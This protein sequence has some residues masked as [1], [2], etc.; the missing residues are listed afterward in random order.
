MTVSEQLVEQ[1]IR[2]RSWSLGN[3][4]STCPKCSHDR[5]NKTEPCLSVTIESDGA[6]WK[7]HHCTWAG[8]VHERRNDY[9][10]APRAV[11]KV[12]HRPGLR[13]PQAEQYLTEKRGLTVE[14]L[15]RNHVGYA[16]V[17]MPG[18]ENG[19]TVGAITF[20]YIRDG[21]IQNVKYRT[22][23]KRFRQE[24]GAAKI[25]YGLDAAADA[26]TLVMCEGEIDKLSFEV[27]GIIAVS[28]PDGAPAKLK[29]EVPDPED[30]RKFEYL[31][32]FDTLFPKVQ[33]II[34]ATDNDSPGDV[35]AE[36]LSRRLGKHRCWRVSWPSLGDVTCKDANEVLLEHGPQALREMVEHAR[37]YPIK[38]LS[39]ASDFVQEIRILY[40]N[41]AR[42]VVST[43]WP[44]MDQFWRVS[45]SQLALFTGHTNHG[46]SQ[47]QD[48]LM[49]N[50]AQFHGWKF[51]LC[52]MEN[53]RDEH[54]SKL[55]EIHAR[56][57]FHDGPSPRMSWPDVEREIRWVDGHFTWIRPESMLTMPTIDWILEQ[58]AMAVRRQ[59]IK[60]L[61]I[62]PF[63]KISQRRESGQTETDFI[64]ELLN[65]VHAFANAYDLLVMFTA[66]PAKPTRLKDGSYPVP[67]LYDISGSA[68]WANICDVGVVV[69]RVYEGELEKP[70]K[71]QTDI[72][73]KKIR[74]RRFGRYGVVR[75]DYDRITGRYTQ[76]IKQPEAA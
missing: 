50:L 9:R 56:A 68:H 73:V 12:D 7:C 61:V 58:A 26:T 59:G 19:Q 60:G 55:A 70:P 20:P 34:L 4:K 48:A 18:C 23:D 74:T 28:V 36:E 44:L 17:W 32:D 15:D 3:H 21:E 75:M 72:H 13:T 69:H 45:T 71:F 30:D 41:K 5:K 35:L 39:V 8:S 14:V 27:A 51:G 63:N 37:P 10:P 54:F 2:L 16:L 40:E 29:D 22:H 38:S 43:G 1:G 25:L 76:A 31:A 49:V 67:S 64:C 52:S 42:P 47:V 33:K 62:D 11:R 65:K 66:H 53:E 57:P 24:K 46:K 6:V